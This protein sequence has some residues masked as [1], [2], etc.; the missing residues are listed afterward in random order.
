MPI[1]RRQKAYNN[2]TLVIEQLQRA[3][4]AGTYTCMAQNKLKQTSRRNVEIQVLSKFKSLFIYRRKKKIYLN[5]M[6]SMRFSSCS[7]TDMFTMWNHV[8]RVNLSAL[9]CLIIVFCTRVCTNFLI[10]IKCNSVCLSRFCCRIPKYHQKS[11]RFN[12]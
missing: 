3:E 12:Q 7:Q 11:C 4:D 1:N 5:T 8:L 2:G 6:C 9:F 10:P